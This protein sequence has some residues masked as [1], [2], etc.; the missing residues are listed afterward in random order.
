MSYYSRSYYTGTGSQTDYTVGFPYLT[1]DHVAVYLNGVSYTSWSWLTSSSIRLA[2]APANGVVVLVKRQTSPQARLVDYVSPSSLNE[3]DLDTDSI[4]GFYLAQEATDQANATVADDPATGQFSAGGKRIVNVAD[5]VNAQDAATKNYVD[6]SMTSQ[7]AQAAASAT[8]ALAS[9]NAAATSETNAAA[10]A[11][12][13]LASKN[14]AA[15]SET[16]ALSSKNAA[17]TSATNAGTSETNALASKNAAATSATNAATS[18]TNALASKNA[19]ATSASNA[20][21]S[22][23]NAAASAAAAAASAGA[24]TPVEVQVKAAATLA[25]PADTDIVASVTP[26][27]TP[28]LHQS[29]WAQWKSAI[30]TA[31]GPAI[32]ALST[33]SP[34]ADSDT[35]ALADSASSNTTKK[36]TFTALWTSY[37]KGKADALYLRLATTGL[38]SVGF[39]VAPYNLGSITSFTINPA[40]GNYQYGTNDA[41]ATWTAPTSDCA[42]D[43]LVANGATAGSITFSGFTVGPVI[44]DALTT[45]NGSKFIISIRRINGVSTYVIKALQ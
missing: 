28:V 13:A 2:V 10:S 40:L 3:D 5:P 41:A 30:W 19:A 24:V 29:T 12:A 16:N 14:A 36:V 22:E 27:A 11:A 15:T 26:S 43:I 38:I 9:K 34:V 18:D 33:K 31:L 21:T 1:K 45:T 37:F 4:Q 44:G 32:A 39:T 7:V 17:A 35:I 8:G 23:T 25:T 20:A 42:V 6:T